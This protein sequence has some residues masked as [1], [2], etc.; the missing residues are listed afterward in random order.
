V[1]SS[2]DRFVV[3]LS[4]L[5]GEEDANLILAD[6]LDEGGSR[7]LAQWARSKLRPQKRLQLVISVLPYKASLRI[8]CHCFEHAL[9]YYR[10]TEETIAGVRDIASWTKGEADRETLDIGCLVLSRV[11][12]SAF[13]VQDVDK[14]AQALHVAAKCVGGAEDCEAA[15]DSSSLRSHAEESCNGSRKAVTAS[16]NMV[17]A[18]Y[19][20]LRPGLEL[21]QFRKASRRELNWQVEAAVSVIEE[22]I[23]H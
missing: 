9:S 22:L 11:F 18:I 23:A 6:M 17:H 16:R 12:P 5:R 21:F 20:N 19:G 1:G 2:Y 4:V 14:T 8:A 13:G 3:A 15:A 7:A 10:E